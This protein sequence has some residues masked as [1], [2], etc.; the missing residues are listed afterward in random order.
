M[1]LEDQIDE[2]YRF[3]IEACK[4]QSFNTVEEVREQRR[5]AKPSQESATEDLAAIQSAIVDLERGD[6]GVP[7]DEFLA[8]TR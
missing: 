2:F 6:R 3:A 5:I 7:A 1:T 4:T 8:K